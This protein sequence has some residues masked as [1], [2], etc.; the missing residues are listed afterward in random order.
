MAGVQLIGREPER[1]AI[2]RWLDGE[3]PGLLTID[4][5]AG[6]GKSTLWSHAV[7]RATER[8]DRVLSWRVSV[9][10]RDLAFSALNGLFDAPIVGGAVEQL[11]DPRRR[12]L[13]IALGRIDPG[14]H[15][16][17]PSLVGLAA[18]DVLQTLAVDRSLVVAIDDIQWADQ[19]SEAALAF[20]ARRLRSAPVGFVLARRTAGQPGDPSETRALPAPGAALADAVE[21]R[22]RIAVGPMSVGALGRLLRERLAVTYPRPLLIRLHQACAGNPFLGL[23]MGRSLI[24]RG[25][26]PAPGEP[27]PVPAEAGPLVRDHLAS[28]GRD[29]RRSLVIVAMTV[30]PALA[31]VRR[32]LGE[33][34]ER[35]VDEAY[36]KGVLAI[37]GQRVRSAHPLFASTAYADSPPGERRALRQA[38]AEIAD[39]PVERAIHLAA[40]VERPDPTIAEAL[41]SAAHVASG[42]GG[43]G[44]AATLL[45]HAARA[46]P[47]VPTRARH[48]IDA[49]EAALAAGDAERA[50]ADLRAVLADVPEGRLRAE[51]LTALGDIVYVEAPDEG[52]G[53]LQA[54]LEHVDG[55]P[56]LEATIHSHIVGAS[57]PD[58]DVGL[59]SADREVE[60]LLRPD[61]RAEPN[62][63]ACALL[64]RAALWLFCGIRVAREDIDR[65]LALL[66]RSDDSFLRRRSE[67]AAQRC[68]WMTGRHAEAMELD[69]GEYRRLTERG[70]SGLLPP[71]LQAMATTRLFSGRPD[72]AE[73]YAGEIDD[74]VE[75]GEEFWRERA[76]MPRAWILAY[77]GELDAAR[78]LALAALS[79]QEAEGDLWEA[80]IWRT[81]LGFVEI[82][83]PDP[84]SAL[85]VLGRALEQADAMKIGLP[86]AFAF[87]GDYVEAAVLAGRVDLAEAAV[88]DRLEDAARR[89]GLPWEEAMAA[90]GR[91]LIEAAAG[92]HDGAVAEYSRALEVLE[93]R[94]GLPL[95]RGRILLLRGEARRRLGQRRAARSDL[96]AATEVFDALGAAVWAG[97]AREELGRLGGRA[98]ARLALTVT[99]RTVAELAATGLTNREIAARLVVSVRTVESQLSAVYR[100]L[101]IRSRAGLRDALAATAEA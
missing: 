17:E 44:V 34:G 79:R 43:P 28:L 14:A 66:D 81:I 37:D 22:Q 67:E 9:A 36:E 45:E 10:E 24:A 69:E 29:A 57:D 13:G 97:R 32:V 4:G 31:L 58:I 16:P 18:A 61:V 15:P 56:L 30:E 75:Q 41:A 89:L 93:N 21:R 72:L 3:R 101:D 64:D 52:L 88:R 48:L 54:A 80:T 55:D 74:L 78:R 25:A 38:L 6:I 40:T 91:G 8:G 83:V 51:A 20:A 82:S 39:D 100:K 68:L 73:R 76:R 90:R 94:S 70:Q 71:L 26:E 65:A 46:E 98:P 92:R 33:A 1:E 85:A 95:D 7:G 59:R 2:E 19:P 86:N 62:Q 27:F 60:I 11:A 42:R 63:L 47:A 87:L 50:A 5:E 99:E 12:A 35:A 53:L 77:A 84:T 23:E 49:A 96:E